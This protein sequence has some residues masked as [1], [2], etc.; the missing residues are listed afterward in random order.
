MGQSDLQDQGANG[1][2]RYVNVLDYLVVLAKHKKFI[3]GF[4][5]IS[6]IVALVLLYW[7]LPRW[8][9]ST[10]SVMP[11]KQKNLVS[12]LNTVA[13][14]TS[15][16]R[17]LGFGGASDDLS[18]F[19]SILKSRRCTESVVRQFDL[20]KV[21]RTENNL[22][23]IKELEDNLSVSLGK[24]DVSL[25]ISV[26]DTDPQRAADM[27]NY[28][29]QLLNTIY[30]DLALTEAKSNREFLEQRYQQNLRDLKNAEDSLEVFQRKY[31][32]YSLPE[33][34]SG[35]LLSSFVPFEKVPEVTMKY[36][37]LYRDLEIQNKIL[38]FALPLY[39]QVRIEEQR[40]TPSVLVLD[41]AIPADKPSKPR[42][43]TIT[44]IVLAGSFLLAYMLAFFFEFVKRAKQPQ[45][46]E[47]EEKINIIQRELSLRGLL[48]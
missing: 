9:K 25:E 28:F 22:E 44:A 18:Q 4:V 14:A 42:R 41:T 29:V 10:A 16:L 35:K 2:M 19:Q 5:F 37:Q 34:M 11:P 38:E 24:E 33:A 48:R 8:Y 12:M 47:D 20:V 45:N 36:L 3:A 26:Y 46:K 7:V 13:R 1:Q 30:L 32:I 40:N 27:A 23:A 39:E 15:S 43:L 17:G 31:G 21:Y 6:V